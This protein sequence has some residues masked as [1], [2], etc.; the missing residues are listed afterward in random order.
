MCNRRRAATRGARLLAVVTSLGTVLGLAPVARADFAGGGA[1][2]SDCYV[3]F[4]GFEITTGK[5]K[6]QCIDGDPCDTDRACNDS[7]TFSVTACTNGTVPGC[8]AA[9]VTAITF[10]KATIAT[11]TLPTS[12]SVCGAASDVV[13]PVRVKGSKKKVG[14]LKVKAKALSDGKPKA[15]KDAFTLLCAPRVGECPPPPSTTTTTLPGAC[16]GLP[17]DVGTTASFLSFATAAGTGD[18]GDIMEF[19]GMA[20]A[21]NPDVTCG[22]LY[23]GGGSNAVPLPSL[24]PDMGLAISKIA[25]CDAATNVATVTGATQLETGSARNCTEAG[26]FFG[27]PLAVPNSNTTPTSTC[28]LNQIASN[29]SGTV[30]CTTGESDITAPLSSIIYLTGDSAT[31]A[32]DSIDGIQPCPLCSGGTC[33]GGPNNGMACT[34]GTTA[35]NA[36]YP[37]SHDCPPDPMFDIGTLPIGFGLSTGTLTWTAQPSGS[38]ARVFSGFCRDQDGTGAFEQPANKCFENGAAVGTGCTGT[39]EACEQRNQGAFGPAGGSV[40]TIT[41][42]GATSGTSLSAGPQ[43]GTLVSIFSIPPTFN[44]TVDSAGD[45]P[46]PGAVALPGTAALCADATACP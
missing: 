13:V 35:L 25:S 33:I 41:V 6:S 3:V 10:K 22:G 9:N 31:D 19:N 15:D 40:R 30:N 17:S 24:V 20:F 39:F 5:N 8:T 2:K 43:P 34:P 1:S 14:K 18:C 36:A 11:P 44:A 26:C 27:A 42:T 38:Q 32:G 12:E 37:T 7:C 4:E 16:C 21:T 29:V 23:F 46:G 28:V 45:L